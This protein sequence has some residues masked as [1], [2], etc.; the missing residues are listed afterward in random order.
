MPWTATGTALVS[1]L[2]SR[3]EYCQ[4]TT[5]GECSP[6]PLSQNIPKA[7][8][9]GRSDV[10]VR[11]PRTTVNFKQKRGCAEGGLA[12]LFHSSVFLPS[13]AGCK[14]IIPLLWCPP[15]LKPL[16]DAVRPTDLTKIKVRRIAY[17]TNWGGLETLPTRMRAALGSGHRRSRA[18][19]RRTWGGGRGRGRNRCSCRSSWRVRC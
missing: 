15:R 2:A 17:R 12:N 4:P 18:W 16:P 3:K 11:F 5:W 13:L 9:P 10:K 19:G 7:V 6:K 8:V 14:Q 1:L